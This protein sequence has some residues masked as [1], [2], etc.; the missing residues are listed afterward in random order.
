METQPI[1]ENKPSKLDKLVKISIM[2][3][4]SIVALSVAYYLVIFLPQKEK[5]KIEQLK[6]EE[7]I[8]KECGVVMN[9]AKD[10]VWEHRKTKGIESISS[11]KKKEEILILNGIFEQC[12]NEKGL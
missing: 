5:T 11:E 7:E 8:K 1:K 6:Q 10:K 12:L 4:A 3:G 2:A 9:E